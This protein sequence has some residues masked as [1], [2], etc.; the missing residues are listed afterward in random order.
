MQS[1]SDGGDGDS[2]PILLSGNIVTGSGTGLELRSMSDITIGTT[3]SEAVVIDNATDGFQSTTSFGLRLNNDANMTIT[4]LDLSY[5]GQNR[6]GTGIYSDGTMHNLTITDVTA[7]NRAQ[8]LRIGDAGQDLTLT[9]NDLSNTNNALYISDFSDGPDTN[10]V[11]V[12]ASGNL[13]WG[14]TQ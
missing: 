1:F 7:N 12:I 5:S 9:N 8:G 10:S 2:F 6:S 11:P 3:G 14:V 4:G 13:F